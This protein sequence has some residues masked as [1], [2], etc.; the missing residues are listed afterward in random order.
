MEAVNAILNNVPM[1]FA[2]GMM[3]NGSVMTLAYF[4]V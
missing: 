2:S 1:G 4:L 3:L